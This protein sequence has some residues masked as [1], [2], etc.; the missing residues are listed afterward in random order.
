MIFFF[1]KLFA[2]LGG[3]RFTRVEVTGR[4]EVFFPYFVRELVG[5]NEKRL[6]DL[7]FFVLFVIL[8]PHKTIV[9]LKGDLRSE[10]L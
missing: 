8:L 7:A 2:C 9:F 6:F 1:A 3:K 5:I 4:C 10:S